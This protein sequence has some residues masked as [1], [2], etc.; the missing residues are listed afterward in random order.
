MSSLGYWRISSLAPRQRRH[1]FV[2]KEMHISSSLLAG[3]SLS[4][5]IKTVTDYSSDTTAAALITLFFQL[6]IEPAQLSRLR[7]EIDQFFSLTK[8]IDSIS[9]SRI[10]FLDAVIN[11]TLRLH[12]PVPSGVQRKTPAE[13]LQIGEVFIPGETIIQVPLHTLFRGKLQ[14]QILDGCWILI[15]DR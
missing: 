11:E 13:G 1:S 15:Y 7:N 3:K 10:S 14:L 6:A 2:W 4:L 5:Q 12:P 8:E 9:L